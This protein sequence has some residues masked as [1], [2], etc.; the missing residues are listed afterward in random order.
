M[1]LGCG[2]ACMKYLLFFFNFIFF[3]CG[4]AIL[5]LGIWLQIDPKVA[6]YISLTFDNSELEVAVILFCAVGGFILLVGFLGCCGACQ[7][8]TCMLCLFAGLMCIIV[9]LQLVAS[10]MAILFKSKIEDELQGHL[11]KEM[12]EH[13]G[14]DNKEA[15]T[16]AINRLQTDMKCCG[17]TNY[18]DYGES[19]KIYND[20]NK[21]VPET[22]CVKAKLDD[23]GIPE[24]DNAD[25]VKCSAEA[26]KDEPD[27]KLL[28]VDGCYKQLVEFLE[29]HTLYVILVGFCLAGVEIFGI[30]FACCVRSKISEQSY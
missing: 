24:L 10:V 8:S 1:G 15:I 21:L 13:L 26:G 2:G 16:K 30:V 6:D 20:T 17:T 12:H 19:S 11:T 25:W 5:G 22:C 23:K 18:K 28:H 3:V 27:V 29:D 4:A 7:E 14:K 9:L